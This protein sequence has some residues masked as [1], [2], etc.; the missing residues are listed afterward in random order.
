M[1]I[2]VNSPDPARFRRR[3]EHFS[4]ERFSF[5]H[6]PPAMPVATSSDS[7]VFATAH[8]AFSTT[9]PPLLPASG[10]ATGFFNGLHAQ[11]KF[12]AAVI[13]IIY[14]GKTIIYLD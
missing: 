6:L 7:A 10:P 12:L 3:A 5:Q 2:V 4:F 14:F 11:S 8:A 13:Q 9:R 1:N